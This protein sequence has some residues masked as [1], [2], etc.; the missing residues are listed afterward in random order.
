MSWL[1]NF[2]FHG[3]RWFF[4]TL[5]PFRVRNNE[6][7]PQSGGVILCS[8]HL[9]NTDPIRVA[10]SQTR[11]INFMAKAELFHFRPVGAVL[12]ALGAFPVVRGKGD[13]SAINTA[14]EILRRGDVLGIFIEGTRSRDGNLLPPKSGAV[15]IAHNCNV[16][17]LPCCITAKNGGLPKLFRRCII[18][19]GELI[20]PEELQIE[21]GTPSELRAASKLVMSRIAALREESLKEFASGEK[22][23]G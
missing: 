4:C 10:Y 2:A 1:Y 15:L 16:P 6:R 23:N 9:S 17:I 8:N 21:H 18:S 11:Q 12:R 20:R 5:M 19:Y 13:K 3:L 22:A 14:H 7:M